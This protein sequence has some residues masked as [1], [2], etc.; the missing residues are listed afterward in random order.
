MNV[1]EIFEKY[2]H[3]QPGSAAMLTIAEVLNELNNNLE[4]LFKKI[5]ESSDE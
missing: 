4:K 5:E 3:I 2:E 1:L